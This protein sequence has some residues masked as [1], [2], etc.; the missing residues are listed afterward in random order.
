MR[1]ATRKY[2]DE[3][4]QEMIDKFHKS[5]LSIHAFEVK[6][7]IGST[8]LRAWLKQSDKGGVKPSNK[9]SNPVGHELLA[10]WDEL[11]GQLMAI[12]TAMKLIGVSK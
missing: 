6:H 12:E 7:K 2:T 1:K 11:Y 8:T 4:K 3:F 10:K 9:K 5:D